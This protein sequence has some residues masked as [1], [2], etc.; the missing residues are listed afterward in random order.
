MIWSMNS[1]RYTHH[2]DRTYNT[3]ESPYGA[4][5]MVGNVFEWVNDWYA[6]DYYSRAPE[7]N[8]KGPDTGKGRSLRGSSWGDGLIEGFRAAN[9]YWYSSSIG[10]TGGRNVSAN[11]CMASKSGF[12]ST[13]ICSTSLV[14]RSL[15]TRSGSER[16]SCIRLFTLPLLHRS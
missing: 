6:S 12:E 7:N 15:N 3:H 1:G 14:T 13:R 4:M 2:V 5:D 11:S 16:S 10:A 9:R 8:P